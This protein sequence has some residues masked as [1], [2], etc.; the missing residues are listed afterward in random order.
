[1]VPSWAVYVVD[2]AIG[3][4][5]VAKRGC[6]KQRDKVWLDMHRVSFIPSCHEEHFG[7]GLIAERQNLVAHL[8]MIDFFP[9]VAFRL[10]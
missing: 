3:H 2:A 8:L 1:M 9:S 6:G 10:P 4:R 7:L 5:G